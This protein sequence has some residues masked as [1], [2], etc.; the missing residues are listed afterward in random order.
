MLQT[1]LQPLVH[2]AVE[3]VDLLG[4]ALQHPADDELDHGLGH[5][6]VARQIAEGHLRLDHPE[7]SGVALGVGVLGTEGGAE[8]IHIAEGHGEVL[9]VQLAGHGQ[10]GLLAE[11]V[12]AVIH[13]AVLGLGHVLQIQGGHLEHLASALAVAAG[14]DGGLDVHKA[15]A[16]EELVHRH[17]RHGADAEGGGEQVGAG[18]QML[19]G[20]QEL[21]AVA[22]LLQGIVGGGLALH[23][24]G[25]GLDLQ[26]LLGL[27]G[28]HHG[29]ADDQRRAHVLGGD[30]LIVGQLLGG[31]DHLQILEAGAVVQ[32]DKAEGLHVADGAGP[33]ADGDLLAAQRFA[34]GKD[35]CDFHTIHIIF[36]FFCEILQYPLLYTIMGPFTRL[37]LPP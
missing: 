17:G 20:T 13:L 19:D 21:H 24:D 7:L 18:P 23:F 16:L 29:A 4:A 26:G 35:C 10:A 30:L 1:L 36:T 32:L 33:A 6:H 31:H 27:G 11:E 28:Q 15:V 3:E 2:E 5:V 9:G 34:V 25:V 37:Y 12:L 22:L 8:G 14:D